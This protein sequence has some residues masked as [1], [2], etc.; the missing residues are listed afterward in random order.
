M[1]EKAET[2]QGIKYVSI[3]LEGTQCALFCTVC[4]P[5]GSVAMHLNR[6]AEGDAG[7]A[8]FVLQSRFF[9]HAVVQTT[10]RQCVWVGLLKTLGAFAES[11]AQNCDF[12]AVRRETQTC[13]TPCR[14]RF[15]RRN[16]FPTTE[17]TVLEIGSFPP[18]VRRREA[19]IGRTGYGRPPS[20]VVTF[21]LSFRGESSSAVLAE[22]P[23]VSGFPD[24]EFLTR[25]SEKSLFV[26]VVHDDIVFVLPLISHRLEERSH[27]L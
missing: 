11:S 26:V 17:L 25:D 15:S 14:K 27:D 10:I 3:D 22:R 13:T 20:D 7:S 1:A 23:F 16:F 18:E 2:L 8:A 4:Q 6:T 19:G 5:R 12:F 9:W 21:R 24:S